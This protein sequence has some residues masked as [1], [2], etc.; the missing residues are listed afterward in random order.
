MFICKIYNHLPKYALTVYFSKQA[1]KQTNKH[2]IITPHANNSV[3][4]TKPHISDL[5]FF[6]YSGRKQCLSP[7]QSDVLQIRSV[8]TNSQF[9]HSVKLICD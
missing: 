7:K 6:F 1:K 4:V 8:L 5:T 2:S 9:L 3:Y